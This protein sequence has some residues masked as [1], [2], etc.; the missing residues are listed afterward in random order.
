MKYLHIPDWLREIYPLNGKES[1]IL[2]QIKQTHIDNFNDNNEPNIITN[3]KY[4]IY[5]PKTP[6][7][8]TH[9]K[10]SYPKG[11]SFFV[12]G[13]HCDNVFHKTNV[14]ED[15]Y[16]YQDYIYQDYV[17]LVWLHVK[18][19]SNSSD[20]INKVPCYLLC[21]VLAKHENRVYEMSDI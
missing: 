12:M 6:D 5:C 10:Y 1:Q 21:A 17:M 14:N 4:D 7:S 3:H 2:Q 8:Y 13:V 11:S 19:L 9:L 16:I 18:P 15:D 20:N